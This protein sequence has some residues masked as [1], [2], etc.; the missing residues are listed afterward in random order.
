[1][2]SEEVINIGQTST[3][4]RIDFHLSGRNCKMSLKYNGNYHFF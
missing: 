1:M 3:N 2:L 4:P